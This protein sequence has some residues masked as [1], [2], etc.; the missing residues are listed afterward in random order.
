[1]AVSVHGVQTVA[2]AAPTPS[3]YPP[4]AVSLQLDAPVVSLNLPAAQL[5]QLAAPAAGACEPSE[6]GKQRTEPVKSV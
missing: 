6:H 4:A 1:M 3:A 2:E 5:V